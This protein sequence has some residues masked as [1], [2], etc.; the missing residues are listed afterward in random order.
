MQRAYYAFA[1]GYNFLVSSCIAEHPTG[2]ARVERTVKYVK[3]SYV[4]TREFHNLV[5]ANRQLKGWLLEEAG[6]RV[7]GTLQDVPLRLF[8]ELEKPALKPLPDRPVELAEWA[9]VKLHP[10]CHVIFQKSYYSAP[11][12]LVGR[13]LWLRA[14]DSIVDIYNDHVLVATHAR[15]QK[16]GTRST[17]DDHLPEAHRAWRQATPERCRAQARDI[18]PACVALVDAL[19]GDRVVD[20]LRSVMGV[21]RLRDKFGPRRLE[22][23]C[24]RALHYGSVGYHPLKLILERGLDQ[25]PLEE[26]WGGQLALPFVEEATR[27]GRDIG[28]MMNE[29]FEA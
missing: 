8:A 4:P 14:G 6:T 29:G 3:R 1:E 17:V 18:G 21:L 11:E 10:D 7:H 9:Q 15:A 27:F 28:Q 19:F 20:R 25:S 2:K 23:A 16:P 5:D 12:A 24:R 13:S 26:D 22:D